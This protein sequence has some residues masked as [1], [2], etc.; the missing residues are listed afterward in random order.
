MPL[1]LKGTESIAGGNAPG[2]LPELSTLKGSHRAKQGFNLRYGFVETSTL[3]G[4][5]MVTSLPGALPPAI[6]GVPFRDETATPLRDETATPFRDET[7]TPF[8]DETATSPAIRDDDCDPLQGRDCDPLHGTRPRPL[9][10]T[11]PHLFRD[12]LRLPTL[13]KRY[14][15]ITASL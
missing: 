4:S 11:R 14:L 6:D 10:G 9:S 3:S 8:R 15:T 2:K 12:E 5:E 13:P 7:A 1:S